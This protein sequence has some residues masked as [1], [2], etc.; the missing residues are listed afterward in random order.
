MPRL[1]RTGR[2]NESPGVD[3]T[4]MALLGM[5]SLE[6][7]TSPQQKQETSISVWTQ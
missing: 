2:V 5:E 7:Q 4:L 1:S 6:T 3:S